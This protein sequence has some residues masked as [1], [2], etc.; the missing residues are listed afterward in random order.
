MIRFPARGGFE[1]SFEATARHLLQVSFIGMVSREATATAAVEAAG[2]FVGWRQRRR[3]IHNIPFVGIQHKGIVALAASEFCLLTTK[4]PF[5][6]TIHLFHFFLLELL[7]AL[8]FLPGL[9][10][11]LVYGGF[12]LSLSTA[13]IAAAPLLV[14]FCPWSDTI[15]GHIYQLCW[16][17]H[18][19]NHPIQIITH[20]A[21][22]FF[23]GNRIG[24]VG[25]ICICVFALVVVVVRTAMDDSIHIQIQSINGRRQSTGCHR[26]GFLQRRGRRRTFRKVIQGRLG[27]WKTPVALV[28]LGIALREP[29]KEFRDSHWIKEQL[30]YSVIM[31]IV[32]Y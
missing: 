19:S 3:T 6:F 2:I 5:V 30:L 21:K 15:N 18:V 32:L 27:I 9:H 10:V 16:L 22:D 13:P 26:I 25:I 20:V 24:V 28:D 8:F 14:H 11:G 7:E 4:F 23:L 12:D 1:F 17:Y 29:S 31:G